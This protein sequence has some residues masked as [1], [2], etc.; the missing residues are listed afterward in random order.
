[1]NKQAIINAL[2]AFINQRSGINFRNYQSGD[3]KASRESFMGDYRPILKRGKQAREMLRS[4]EL[5]DSITAENI[6]SAT[7]AFSGRLQIVERAGKV[8]VEYCPRQYFPT[9]YRSAACAVLAQC[10]WDYWRE[11][12]ADTIGASPEY[13]RKQAGRELGRGIAKDW[14]N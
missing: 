13:I 14:F 9:E 2:R 12:G 8:E 4:I 6:L 10:L 11:N 3:W 7:R 1:M 5:R